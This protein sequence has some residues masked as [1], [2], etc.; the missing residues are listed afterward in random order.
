M[1][2][3]NLARSSDEE[4]HSIQDFQVYITCENYHRFVKSWTRRKGR[5]IN[6]PRKLKPRLIALHYILTG[7]SRGTTYAEDEVNAIIQNA[8]LFDIDHVQ[9]RRYLVD[10]GMLGRKGDGSQY[11][12][13]RTYL[14]LVHW[15]PLI[16][17]TNLFETSS[18]AHLMEA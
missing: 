16:T 12:V 9:V 5:R 3:R 13:I 18:V 14:A 7:F 15:D 10:Y 11:R 17:G 1:T 6:F 2:G 8:N 4:V